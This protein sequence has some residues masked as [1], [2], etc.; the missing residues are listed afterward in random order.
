M[1]KVF[2][3]SVILA[4]LTAAFAFT[5]CNS[6]DDEVSINLDKTTFNVGD[7]VTGVITST[8]NLDNV[9]ILIIDGLN[10]DTYLTIT[11]FKATSPIVKSGE[12]YT[13]RI[14]G[15]SAGTYKMRATDKNG[16]ESTRGFTVTSSNP[17]IVYDLNSFEAKE[18]DSYLY[19]YDNG[20]KTGE[21]TIAEVS[22]SGDG[23][24]V[25]FSDGIEATL[26]FLGDSYLTVN[27]TTLNTDG[28]RA[29]KGADLLL[30]LYQKT[31]TIV[32]GQE[33]TLGTDIDN[34]AKVTKF[35]K[36]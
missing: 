9:K 20:A 10:E 24:K 13:F 15:L 25:V 21:F 36:Q 19:Q 22:A 35:K 28:V 3:L 5:S 12:E 29:N 2:N 8:A 4:V 7:P 14:T 1:K 30:C 16:I 18:G 32:A 33:A 27:G 6:D 23:F 34:N 17:T 31:N 11:D 26:S